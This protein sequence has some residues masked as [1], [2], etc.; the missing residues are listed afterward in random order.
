MAAFDFALGVSFGRCWRVRVRGASAA[1]VVR[2]GTA[3]VLW[4]SA[5]CAIQTVL[6]RPRPARFVVF[7]CFVRAMSRMRRCASALKQVWSTKFV[8]CA[9]GGKL[10]TY[11]TSVCNGS[12]L[13]MGASVVRRDACAVQEEGGGR[14]RAWVKGRRCGM[15]ARDAAAYWRRVARVCRVGGG[16]RA[17]ASG[18]RISVQVTRL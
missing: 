1:D 18:G 9:A 8:E 6:P 17:G 7:V 4:Q 11:V 5:L 13:R 3:G 2:G 15:A 16:S 12:T 14:V 10:Y